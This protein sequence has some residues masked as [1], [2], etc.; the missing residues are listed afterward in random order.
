[1]LGVQPEAV[2]VNDLVLDPPARQ[3]LQ[4][5]FLLKGFHDI[6]FYPD[7]VLDHIWGPDLEP[8]E[9]PMVAEVRL[10]ADV[11]DLEQWENVPAFDLRARLAVQVSHGDQIVVLQH[12]W[13]DTKFLGNQAHRSDAAALAIAPVTHLVQRLQEMPASHT[14]CTGNPNDP[15]ATF[16]FRWVRRTI[17]NS[18]WGQ[19]LSGID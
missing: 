13:G 14:F 10:F 5:V 8:R 15:T 17:A 12:L 18:R 7:E 6:C 11:V 2:L 3:P 19:R 1:M 4:V 9:A 16:G